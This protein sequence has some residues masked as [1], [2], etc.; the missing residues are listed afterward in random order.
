MKLPNKK[1]TGPKIIKTVYN[2]I[3]LSS[4]LPKRATEN[5]ELLWDKPSYYKIANLFMEE[6]ECKP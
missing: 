1:N 6:F 3:L 2:N 5:P 4:T